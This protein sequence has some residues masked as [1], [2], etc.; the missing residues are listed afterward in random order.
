MNQKKFS[1]FAL[2]ILAGAAILHP[3]FASAQG[4]GAVVIDRVRTSLTITP[5]PV[6]PTSHFGHVIGAGDV[7]VF[8]LVFD[9]PGYCISPPKELTATDIVGIELDEDGVAVRRIVYDCK[10][11]SSLSYFPTVPGH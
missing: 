5:Q 7:E 2:V 1:R 6:L 8:Y 3:I 9:Q 4:G 10:T 11:T